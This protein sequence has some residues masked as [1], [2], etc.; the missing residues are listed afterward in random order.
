MHKTEWMGGSVPTRN[1]TNQ[2][3]LTIAQEISDYLA[4]H[5]KAA[6]SLEGVASWWLARQRYESAE[7]VVQKALE[8]LVTKGV[9]E[10]ISNKGGKTVFSYANKKIKPKCY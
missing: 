2:D 7:D 4:E 1:T 9:V 6:D 10:K 3:I 5:P 8:H